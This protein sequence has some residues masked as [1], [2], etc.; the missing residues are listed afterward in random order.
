MIIL[1]QKPFLSFR[2]FKITNP[3][4]ASEGITV[5]IRLGILYSKTF[6]SDWDPHTK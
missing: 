1:M 2:K 5:C 6:D 3:T 4:F